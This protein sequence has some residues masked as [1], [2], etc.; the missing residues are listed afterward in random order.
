LLRAPNKTYLVTS[1]GK[2]K[3]N[4]FQARPHGYLL[5]VRD[6]H[7]GDKTDAANS[8]RARQPDG[9]CRGRLL[10]KIADI[11]EDGVVDLLDFSALGKYWLEP[12]AAGY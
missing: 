10:Q 5:N 8:R 6:T 4:R 7:A 11:N 9:K 1:Y 12:S 3:Y 2:Q